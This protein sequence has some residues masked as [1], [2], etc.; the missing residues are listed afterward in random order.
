MS[1]FLYAGRVEAKNLAKKAST[2]FAANSFV[3]QES[4]TGFIEPATS[5]SAALVGVM[6]EVVASTDD[7]Y[8]DNST[9]LV[10]LPLDRSTLF[11]CTTAADIAT[12]DV[13]EYHDLTDAVTV[14]PS[15]SSTDVVA[16]RAFLAA[17]EGVY[18]IQKPYLE[19]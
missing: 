9:K 13:G 11:R 6:Q 8:A 12:T 4:G 16:L 7:D 19:A 18:S 1:I 17:R 15:A 10:I 5:S 14:N 2:A 3:S